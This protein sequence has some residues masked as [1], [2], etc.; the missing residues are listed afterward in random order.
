MLVPGSLEALYNIS[1]G[2]NLLGAVLDIPMI[3]RN[4]LYEVKLAY[5]PNYFNCGMLLMNLT[6]M[7]GSDF[8]AEV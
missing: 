7:R 5:N 1:L 8:I 4:E 2:N 6:Q 3:S